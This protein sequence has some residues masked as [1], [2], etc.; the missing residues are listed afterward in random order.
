M[1][2]E[3]RIDLN[4]RLEEFKKIQEKIK[5]TTPNEDGDI[6]WPEAQ[7]ALKDKE[8]KESDTFTIRDLLNI[9]FP[10]TVWLV[11]KLIPA[12]GFTAITGAPASYKSFITEHLALC[13]ASGQPFLDTIPTNQGAVLIIDKENP[14]SLLQ[15]RFK[16]MGL[17]GDPPVYFLQ[18]PDQ[19][20]IMKDDHL[21]WIINFIKEKNIKLV[22]L[23][24]FSH[25]HRGDENDSMAVVK[26]FERLKQFKCATIFIHHHRKSIKFFTGTVLETIRGSSDIGAEVESH[27][28]LDVVPT[29]IKIT[30][31]KNRRAE[32]A[33]P[34]TIIPLI[35]EDS[36]K[37]EYGGEMEEE[38]SKIQKAKILIIELLT[39]NGET[40]RQDII[41][42]L[43]EKVGQRSIDTVL[44]QMETD[45]E[46]TNRF[47][48]KN[49]YISLSKSLLQSP[50]QFAN[51]EISLSEQSYLENAD[52]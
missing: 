4:L 42:I 21:A 29:G 5:A 7:T 3:E 12:E 11:D 33:K 50:L 47:E 19:F 22:I 24:S 37:F 35:T 6:D 13:I 43:S 28:A 39:V 17:E 49:K 46:T 38:T 30:Q 16:K 1:E 31:S 44:K 26:T 8:A 9:N 14:L 41:Q 48:K 10:P 23:D 25:I 18:Q 15:E 52:Q 20:E 40:K 36:I 34:F 32:L 45:N 2:P 51:D 27:L